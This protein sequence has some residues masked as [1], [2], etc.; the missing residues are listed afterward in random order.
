MRAIKDETHKRIVF[1]DEPENAIHAVL[2][3]NE[4]NNLFIKNGW[5]INYEIKDTTLWLHL[6]S[7]MRP[8]GLLNADGTV[9]YV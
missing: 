1:Y 9:R 7:E 8:L 5:N 2:L 3:I 4:K 6:N